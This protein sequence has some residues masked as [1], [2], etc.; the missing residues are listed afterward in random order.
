MGLHLIPKQHPST[1]PHDRRR[2]DCSLRQGQKMRVLKIAFR[3]EI[4]R[5][6]IFFLKEIGASEFV[7]K[8]IT[9]YG[10]IF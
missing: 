3:L 2:Y 1:A 8:T 7:K 9:L 4:A 10:N 5:F 6:A